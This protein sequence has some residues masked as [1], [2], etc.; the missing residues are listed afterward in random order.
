MD[1]FILGIRLEGGKTA[2]TKAQTDIS[3]ILARNGYTSLVCDIKRREIVKKLA[4]I[5]Y[6]RKL[7]KIPKNGY[8][9]LQYPTVVD[10]EFLLNFFEKRRDIKLAVLVHDVAFFRN[11][12]SQA[13]RE[14]EE[15]KR[16]F[17]R[18][19]VITVHNESMKKAF[20][21][22]GVGADKKSIPL[23]IFDY[24]ADGDISAKTYDKDKVVVAGNLSKEKSGYLYKLKGTNY[25]LTFS[26]YG[27][28][29]QENET[30]NIVYNG[31]FLPEELPNKLEG[32][33][34][35]VWDGEEI[36]TCSGIYGEYLKINNPHKLSLYLTSQLPVIVWSE[37]ATADFVLKNGVGIAVKSLEELEEKLSNLTDE[38]FEK[39]IENTKR[40]SEELR[41]GKYT[42]KAT[43]E[44]ER[45]INNEI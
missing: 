23:E 44:A 3:T 22:Y 6:M 41:N 35:L 40:V 2:G 30:P 15:E 24:L 27:I 1:K 9:V 16:L 33:F 8:V 7:K 4:Y 14:A 18:A 38:E 31:S 42:L 25:G 11:S 13:S 28:N 29:Y 19:D 12:S 20:E 5:S 43:A 21:A 45:R 36:D 32:G 10:M 34:G 26:L 17:K 39:M 37:S